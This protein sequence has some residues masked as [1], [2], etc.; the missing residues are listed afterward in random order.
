MPAAFVAASKAFLGVTT[1]LELFLSLGYH[2]AQVKSFF[3]EIR[4]TIKV[5]GYDDEWVKMMKQNFGNQ[6]LAEFREIYLKFLMDNCQ[7][8][9]DNEMPE[10][11][12]KLIDC[13]KTLGDNIASIDSMVIGGVPGIGNMEIAAE[14]TNFN[15]LPLG[16]Y[17]LEPLKTA[18]KTA[19]TTP[20]KKM[21]PEEETKLLEVFKKYDKDGSGAI[22][23]HELKAMVAELGG[24]LNDK[25]AEAAMKEL[26]KNGQG[27]CNF[28]EFKLF[29]T[30]KSSLGGYSSVALKFLKL[31]IAAETA[32]GRYVSGGAVPI[33][34]RVLEDDDTAIKIKAAC[35]PGMTALDSKVKAKVTATH[36]RVEGGAKTL[37]RLVIRLKAASAEKAGA[38]VTMMNQFKEQFGPMLESTLPILPE[39]SSD[40]DAVEIV[41][42]APEEIISEGM[43]SEKGDVLQMIISAIGALK[44]VNLQFDLGTSVEDV[45]ASPDTPLPELFGG[46]SAEFGISCSALGKK[47]FIDTLSIFGKNS[48]VPQALTR[49]FAG[50]EYKVLT[51]FHKDAIGKALEQLLEGMGMPQEM[52]PMMTLTGLRAFMDGNV[53]PEAIEEMGPIMAQVF[54][55]LDACVGVDSILVEGCVFGYE[56]RRWDDD[57]KELAEAENFTVKVEFSNFTPFAIMQYMTANV[58]TQLPAP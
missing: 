41:F 58:R 23:L 44:E 54:S 50:M 56:G 42:M 38:A 55:I 22:D 34:K 7:I 8:G 24:T 32:L 17:M 4:S 43:R 48:G 19:G 18:A 29:W 25:D 20:Q 45:L 14:C 36:S 30:S 1:G 51:G 6:S 31:K 27:T 26:D 47:L 28:E 46:A 33:Y 15:P 37:A 53:P 16:A 21:T 52:K 12:A 5:R 35:T 39:V 57:R 40:G 10:E 3:S 49:L 11:A 13:I 2:D 9:G